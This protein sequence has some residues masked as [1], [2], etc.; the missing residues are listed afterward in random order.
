[1]VL[2]AVIVLLHGSVNVQ[3]SVYVPPHAVCEPVITPVAVPEISQ[4][5]VCPL[6]YAREVP[7]GAVVPQ[8][9]VMFGA[10]ANTAGGAGSTVMVLE[11][12]IVLLHGS[13]NVQVSV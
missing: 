4:V 7:T 1:M 3:V 8:G 2:E 12:V 13:V 10:V 11:A 6:V 5:P 9:I